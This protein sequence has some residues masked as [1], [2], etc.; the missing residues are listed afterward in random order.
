MNK[1][2]FA[3]VSGYEAAVAAAVQADVHVI[4]AEGELLEQQIT[5]LADETVRLSVSG[6]HN[7]VL[8][9][10]RVHHVDYRG[11]R[12]LA[13]RARFLRA[14]GGDLKICGLSLYLASIFRASGLF[15]EIE[16]HDTVQSASASFAYAALANEAEAGLADVSDAAS[17]DSDAAESL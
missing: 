15:G 10:S 16:V 6:K 12:Q 9:L 8:D 3:R 7:V 14:A 2:T 4:A 5:D 17:A 11:V 1:I 13:A